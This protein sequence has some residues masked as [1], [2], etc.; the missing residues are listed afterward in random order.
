MVLALGTRKKNGVTNGSSRSRENMTAL[1]DGK[2]ASA[3]GESAFW[4]AEG[5]KGNEAFTFLY[6]KG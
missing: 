4:S 2:Q 6:D 1:C 3:G 5:A